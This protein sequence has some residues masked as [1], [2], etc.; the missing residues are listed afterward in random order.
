MKSMGPLNLLRNQSRSWKSILGL[1]LLLVGVCLLLYFYR[2]AYHGFREA[3]RFF[4]SRRRV[5]A[6]IAS[7]GSKAPFAFIGLQFL[8]VMVAPI[9]GEFSGFIGGYLLGT[10][11]GFW[12]S[13]IGLTLGSWAAF[14]ISR[15]FGLPL[16]RRFVGKEIMDKF[17]YLMEHQGALFSFMF[18]LI[19][20]LP[21][22]F[23][24]YLLGLSPMHVLTFVVVSTVGRIPGTLLLSMEGETLRA[25]EYRAFFV[26][27]GIGLIALILAFAY[28]DRIEHWLKH[29][30]HFHRIRGG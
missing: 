9:P 12:Y 5:S 27:L 11:A 20:G 16:V 17:G 6:Y 22:D 10:L 23:F 1:A 25:A 7:F 8:Q 2:D 18:F 14:M 15:W 21:K 3:L 13:T 28:R 29:R 24:R 19:P 30:K 4:S 26:F